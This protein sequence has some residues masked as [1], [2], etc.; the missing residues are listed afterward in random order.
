M[1][2][3]GMA[4]P[5]ALLPDRTLVVGIRYLRWHD[6]NLGT[7][8]FYERPDRTPYLIHLTRE[9]DEATVFENLVR[10]LQ[11]GRVLGSSKKKGF[12]HGPWPLSGGIDGHS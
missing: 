9:S 2:T 12:I 11:I 10:I 1:A 4:F 5:I 3:G 6:L 8:A 7:C